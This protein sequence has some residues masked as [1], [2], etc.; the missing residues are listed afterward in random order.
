[1][2]H[3]QELTRVISES[4][5]KVS[6]LLAKDAKDQQKKTNKESIQQEV[7]HN[8]AYV[9]EKI[10]EG[11]TAC[12][13]ALKEHPELASQANI[14]IK[15]LTKCFSVIKTPN[16]FIELGNVIANNS[17]WK[18]QL[19]ISNDCMINLYQGA[20]LLFEKKEIAEAE[21]AFFAICSLDPSQFIFWV[22][23]GHACF[24]E[25]NYQQAIQAYSMAAALHKDDVWSRIWAANC[26]EEE[27]DFSNA[28]LALDEALSIAKRELPKNSEL[29]ESIKLKIQ[30][31]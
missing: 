27:N 6:A 2:I 11:L 21:S 9:Q 14:V 20:R 29:I 23:L 26:F 24:H 28:K 3:T 22:G 15:E 17:S 5:E 8:T 7:D 18:K 30:Q 10:A 13:I 4:I 31:I 25:M 1:M 16:Q 12:L 19:G